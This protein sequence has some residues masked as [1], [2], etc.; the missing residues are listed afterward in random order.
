[1]KNALFASAALAALTLAAPS[2]A[3]SVGSVGANYSHSEVEIGGFEGE[4]DIIASPWTAPSPMTT[5]PR[6]SSA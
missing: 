5:T 3:Q 1:M 6:K 2:F 4:G